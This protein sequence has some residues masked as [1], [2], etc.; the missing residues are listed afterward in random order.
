MW[1]ELRNHGKLGVRLKRDTKETLR[2][3]VETSL[4]L[5]RCGCSVSANTHILSIR[6]SVSDLKLRKHTTETVT[7]VIVCFVNCTITADIICFERCWIIYTVFS[8]Y[9]GY[10]GTLLN[11]TSRIF[12]N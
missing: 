2:Y 1:S 7:E 3:N 9:P 6:R 10:L 11:S 4:S 8:R 12:S 5:T